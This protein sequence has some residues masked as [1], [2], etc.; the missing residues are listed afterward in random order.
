[1]E[2]D[3]QDNDTYIFLGLSMRSATQS[4]LT[5]PRLV[6]VPALDNQQLINVV[7]VIKPKQMTAY[8]VVSSSLLLEPLSLT[9]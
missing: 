9:Q 6:K 1:M 7:F 2:I 5:L 4:G 3:I 8:V